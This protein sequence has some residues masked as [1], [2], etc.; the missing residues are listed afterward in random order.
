MGWKG[1]RF[2]DLQ[3]LVIQAVGVLLLADNSI[4]LSMGFLAGLVILSVGV[5]GKSKKPEFL[6]SADVEV[7][8]LGAI[9]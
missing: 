9:T 4:L 7:C 5:L 2:Y 1:S 8:T 3:G 6:Q